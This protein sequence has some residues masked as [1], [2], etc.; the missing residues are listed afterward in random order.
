MEILDKEK[1]LLTERMGEKLK[2]LCLMAATFNRYT[3]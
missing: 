2:A 1:S 3:I